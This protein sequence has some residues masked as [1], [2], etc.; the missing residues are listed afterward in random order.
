[1]T[2]DKLNPVHPGE[3]LAEEFLKPMG[4]TP[5]Q[6][7]SDIGVNITQLDKIIAEKEGMNADMALRLARYFGTSPRFWTGLQADYDLDVTSEYLGNR[8]EQEVKPRAVAAG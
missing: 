6:L 3:I 1:M 7:A 5:E 4:L 2:Q 8:L